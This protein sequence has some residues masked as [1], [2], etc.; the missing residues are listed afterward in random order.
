M[1]GNDNLNSTMVRLKL[2]REEV[3]YLWELNLNSTMVRL[4]QQQ[5]TLLIKGKK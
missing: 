5:F 4:K 2:D 3:D 1:G